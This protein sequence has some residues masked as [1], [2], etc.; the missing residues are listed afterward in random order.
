MKNIDTIAAFDFDKTLTDRDSFLPF[1]FFA[2]GFSNAI[3]NLIPLT[4]VFLGFLIGIYSR[5]QVKESILTRFFKD[6]PIDHLEKLGKRY[7]EEK[8]DL[9]LKPEAMR[10]FKWH[11]ALGHRCII[12]SAAPDFY[13]K[14]WGA[15]HGFEATL[16]S[17]LAVSSSGLVT[18]KLEG[19]NCRG[20]E[21]ERRLL[22]YLGP[23]EYELYA[24]GD[25][26]G[27]AELL[28]MA[29]FPFYRSFGKHR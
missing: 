5:Q 21:K 20:P 15:K 19:L 3:L 18:G 2:V 4:P 24:Y 16:A 26:A 6:I 17:E 28:Q 23:I 1:L 9:Y 25:S 10:C 7:S 12:V 27:D 22:E 13:L 11:K 14:Y 8:L 29:D